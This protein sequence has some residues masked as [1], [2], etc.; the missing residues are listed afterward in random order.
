MATPLPDATALAALV[1]SGDASPRELVDDA[2]ARIER[3]N[4]TVNAVIHERFE[5]ARSEADG[6]LPDGP[7][8]GVPFLVKDLGCEI[9]GEPHHLGNQALKDADARAT[10]T[11]TLYESFRDS[12]LITLGRT[13]T[14]EFGGTI[15]T[16]PLAYGPSRNP[17]DTDHST[18]GSSG[19][20]AA[21]VAAG[22]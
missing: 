4:P 3:V 16:E 21:A 14:P 10:F 1:R 7:F 9:A 13:N 12:G 15:T 11:S 19:G 20:S 6:P 22:M 2:I 5:A 8:R 17:W 18:G